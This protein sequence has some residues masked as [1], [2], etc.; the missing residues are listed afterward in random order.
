MMTKTKRQELKVNHVVLVAA[1]FFPRENNPKFAST[2]FQS[3][4]KS[5]IRERKNKL[6]TTKIYN[7]TQRAKKAADKNAN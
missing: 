4:G 6:P 7:T 2:T 3:R 5:E 1:P